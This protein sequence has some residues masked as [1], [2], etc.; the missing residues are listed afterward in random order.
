MSESD[1]TDSERRADHL[2]EERGKIAEI[3][4]QKDIERQKFMARFMET[5]WT[6]FLVDAI[7][8]AWFAYS[9]WPSLNIATVS[10]RSILEL[11]TPILGSHALWA[12]R[13]RGK[14]CY[15][16]RG[17]SITGEGFWGER[18]REARFAILFHWFKE[19]RRDSISS[20]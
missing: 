5:Y 18:V 13:S 16:N 14:F 1:L 9:L 8:T 7:A 19:N 12:W 10:L 2:L 4:R 3:L 6:V 11:V 17:N 15:Y 20:R